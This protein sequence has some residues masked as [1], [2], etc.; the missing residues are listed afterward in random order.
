M[1]ST[2]LVA[3]VSCEERPEIDAGEGDIWV[4]RGKFLFPKKFRTNA[5]ETA[6]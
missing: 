1:T 3:D 2:P 6:K 5:K 4:V